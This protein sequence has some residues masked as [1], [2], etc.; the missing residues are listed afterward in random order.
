VEISG[1]IY[2]PRRV[3]G[4]PLYRLVEQHLDEPLRVWPTR[5]V[6]QHGPL[7]PAVER[8]LRELLK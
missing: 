5:F 6:R 7:R 2:K 4:S 8:V 1:R 3:R